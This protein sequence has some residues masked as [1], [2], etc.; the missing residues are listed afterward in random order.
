MNNE[1]QGKSIGNKVSKNL[2]DLNLFN[3]N[4]NSFNT[5][6]VLYNLPYKTQNMRLIRKIK[7]Q[8]FAVLICIDYLYES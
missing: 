1:N 5:F 7:A 4:A 2:N 6:C 8:I 3:L